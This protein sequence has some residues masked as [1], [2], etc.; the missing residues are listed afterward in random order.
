MDS[1]PIVAL[2]IGT[3]KVRVLV[4]EPRDDDTLEVIGIGE[5]ASSGVRKSEIVHLDHAVTCVRSA[6]HIAEETSNV[7]IRAANLLV[8][9]GHIQCKINRGSIPLVDGGEI[10]AED[11]EHVSAAARAVSLSSEREILHTITQNFY[12]DE[13]HGVM[14]PLGM[15][16]TKL[17]V[18]MMILHGVRTRLRNVI[19]VAREIPIEVPDVAF[20]GLCAG[21]A[22]LSA[23]EKQNGS[24]V[25]DLGGGSTNY[26]AYAGGTIAA[27]G[28]FG[29]GGDH[30]TNDLARG[31]R[32]TLSQAEQLKEDAGSAVID[33]AARSQKLEVAADSATAQAKYVRRGDIQLIVNSRMEEIFQL[34]KAQI[35]EQ[36]LLHHL[37]AGVI[38]V[39][40]GA[41]LRDVQTL[42]SSVFGLPCALGR[43]RDIS[44]LA[45]E[46]S[47]PE[48]A[49][50]LGLLRYVQ[51]TSRREENRKPRWPWQR[52]LGR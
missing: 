35:D 1:A 49:A 40:G 3:T 18:D 30:V 9:G 17:A 20:S 46:T 5:S 42:A 28:A 41:Y 25:I 37:G 44:G 12:I 47:G 38:L 8:S 36:D 34:V 15:E 52:L 45:T 7:S 29:V 4:A 39:G 14:N 22:V 6:I 24:V 26:I 13:Q 27:A 2:E 23:E 21:L 10:T 31:L 50:P 51:R 16:G 43:P 33:R 48:F 19:K 11:I 32:L